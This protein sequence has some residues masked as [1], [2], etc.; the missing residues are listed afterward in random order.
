[1]SE[2]NLTNGVILS[3]DVM[4]DVYL[5]FSSLKMIWMSDLKKSKYILLQYIEE[6]ILILLKKLST[7]FNNLN[8]INDKQKNNYASTPS[9]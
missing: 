7:I 1:M 6:K 2:E 3:G 4:Y 8:K 5:K 9:Y